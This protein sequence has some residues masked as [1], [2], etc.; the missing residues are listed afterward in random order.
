MVSVYIVL[1][2]ARCMA[3]EAIDAYGG[4]IVTGA[5]KMLGAGD[6]DSYRIGPVNHVAG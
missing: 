3:L 2:R 6:R 5:A 1:S 4:V